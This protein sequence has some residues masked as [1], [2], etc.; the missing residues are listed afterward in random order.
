MLVDAYFII[1]LLQARGPSQVYF[2]SHDQLIDIP[3]T[4]WIKKKYK[5]ERLKSFELKMKK[6][7]TDVVIHPELTSKLYKILSS[8]PYFPFFLKNIANLLPTRE[9]AA[10]WDNAEDTHHATCLLCFTAKETDYHIWNCPKIPHQELRQLCSLR[11]SQICRVKYKT[12][13]TDP[14]LIMDYF[15]NAC[16]PYESQG[17]ITTEMA[18]LFSSL[19]TIH[20]LET[21][22]L[23]QFNNNL[24]LDC[25]IVFNTSFHDTAWKS[26][27]HRTHNVPI[28]RTVPNTPLIGRPSF[29]KK[30]RRPKKRHR[31]AFEE[32][33]SSLAILYDM[34]TISPSVKHKRQLAI[35]AGSTM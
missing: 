21:S 6:H 20:G 24:L 30:Q 3:I 25:C 18:H 22:R 28:T 4:E 10:R 1:E 35:S 2:H 34:F 15:F 5:F 19:P 13:Q 27:N 12:L 8:K 11:F 31:Q 14:S 29:I 33:D 7:F 32:Y 9:R 23:Q 16:N 17:L 26:R